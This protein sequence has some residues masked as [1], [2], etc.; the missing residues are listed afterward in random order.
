MGVY[1]ESR[2]DA[3]TDRAVTSKSPKT[4]AHGPSPHGFGTLE[5]PIAR[6]IL[7]EGL[8]FQNRAVTPKPHRLSGAPEFS[9]HVRRG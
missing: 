3:V 5:A 8:A 6:D 2:N 7:G 9:V 1:W 4:S